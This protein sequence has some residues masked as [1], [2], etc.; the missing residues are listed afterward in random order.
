MKRVIWLFC[1]VL[2]IAIGLS[3]QLWQESSLA[4]DKGQSAAPL[5]QIQLRPAN[6][7]IGEVTKNT[8]ETISKNA[9]NNLNS[10]PIDVI[11]LPDCMEKLENAPNVPLELRQAQAS[12]FQSLS[13]SNSIDGQ[14]VF[15]LFSELSDSESRLDR[16]LAFHEKFPEE[17]TSPIEIVRLC[18]VLDD[19][20]SCDLNTVQNAIQTS[21]NNGEIWLQ[22]I[23]YF[24]KHGDDKQV[25]S[26]I[27][28]LV[29]TTYLTDNYV[30]SIELY[31]E[32]LESVDI[33]NLASNTLSA[34]GIEAAKAWGTASIVGWCSEGVSNIDK[35]Q[36]CLTLGAEMERRGKDILV[37]SIG[38]SIQ[39]MVF[40]SESNEGAFKAADEKQQSLFQVS[41]SE[42]YMNASL[43]ML[44][45]EGLLKEWLRNRHELG[46]FEAQ[47]LLVIEVETHLKN[48]D[49]VS[50]L[51]DLFCKEKD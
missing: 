28:E 23:N 50:K 27:Q 2:L 40:E 26:A 25:M 19:H 47:K 14:L 22:A 33:G 42:H 9:A 37:Q 8:S 41:E 51:D 35:S 7:I 10:I 34:M 15:A 12:Y 39:L 38:L 16:L 21:P 18:S 5:N 48:P 32:A 20:S 43:L 46:E 3:L 6:V 1:I 24:A 45:D 49:Y 13:T 17:L 11:D 30:P 29:Q 4:A 44:Q 31:T 36:A